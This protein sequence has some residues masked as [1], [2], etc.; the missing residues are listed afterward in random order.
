MPE[1]SEEKAEAEKYRRLLVAH[2]SL[3]VAWKGSGIDAEIWR[4]MLDVA[5]LGRAW[6]LFAIKARLMAACLSL[7]LAEAL[8]N[9]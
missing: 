8:E 7:I 5:A 3:G 1:G 2:L 9:E 4:V 6:V